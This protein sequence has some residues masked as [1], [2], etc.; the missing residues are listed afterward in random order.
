M[1]DRE[2]RLTDAALDLVER[3]IRDG[4]APSEET[5]MFFRRQDDE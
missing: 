3:R 1:A 4:V 5:I 2:K